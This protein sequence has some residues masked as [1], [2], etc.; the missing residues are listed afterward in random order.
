MTRSDILDWLRAHR[1][2]VHGD[3]E[4]VL[5]HA[6]HEARRRASQEAWLY[7]KQI[8]EQQIDLWNHRSRGM[9]SRE[10]WVA[11]EFCH[12]LARELRGLEPHPE[13]GDEEH[14][15]DT[16]TLGALERDAR[17][18]LREWISEIAGDEEHRVWRDVVRFTDARARSLVRE[19][20][21]STEERWEYT[22]SYAE[23]AARLAAIL[24]HDYE[25]H[26][27]ETR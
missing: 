10:D 2:S 20:A 7:A 26:A 3:P 5:D 8:A 15:M 27:R 18:Q 9:H 14:W 23:T 25:E 12:E 22:H 24:A 16:E 11:R 19:G 17:D 13:P 6:E 1:E 21:V 4:Q